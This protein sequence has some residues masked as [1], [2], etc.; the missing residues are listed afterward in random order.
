MK[1]SKFRLNIATKCGNVT[2]PPQISSLAIPAIQRESVSISVWDIPAPLLPALP[3]AMSSSPSN[4]VPPTCSQACGVQHS[5]IPIYDLGS[6]FTSHHID[7]VAA[8]LG[9]VLCTR[10]KPSHGGIVERPFGTFNSE[11]FPPFLATPPVSSNP[12]APRSK[13]KPAYPSIS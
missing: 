6:D 2:T 7:H 10:R 1:V 8:S 3:C 4:T 12:T 13:L 9:I 11:F 5:S